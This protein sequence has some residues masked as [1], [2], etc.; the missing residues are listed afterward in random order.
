MTPNSNARSP[1][2]DRFASG[3]TILTGCLPRSGGRWRPIWAF[4]GSCGT[5]P[6]ATCSTIRKDDLTYLSGLY[7]VRPQALK[8]YLATEGI[9]IAQ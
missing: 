2:T 6:R 3:S 4:S 5:I 7:G 1:E 8:D 9:L